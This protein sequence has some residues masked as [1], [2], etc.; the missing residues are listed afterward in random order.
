VTR[1][2]ARHPLTRSSAV[3]EAP[4]WFFARQAAAVLLGVEPGALTVEVMP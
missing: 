4:T 1:W 2:I 3:V